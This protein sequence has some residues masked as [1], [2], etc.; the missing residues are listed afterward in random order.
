[1]FHGILQCSCGGKYYVALW[2]LQF[3]I[4]EVFSVVAVLID[5]MTIISCSKNYFKENSVNYRYRL[6]LYLK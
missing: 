3:L 4:F 2:G 5:T 6:M 1:M